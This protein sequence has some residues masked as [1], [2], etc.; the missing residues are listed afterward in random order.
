MKIYRVVRFKTG[1]YLEQIGRFHAANDAKALE[2]F[3]A[4]FA[5][6][7]S[8]D[9]YCLELLESYEERSITTRGMVNPNS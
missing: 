8:H 9:Q 5:G 1:S 2:L 7:H 3:D 4:Q 6:N